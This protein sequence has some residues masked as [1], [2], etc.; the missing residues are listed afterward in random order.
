MKE[1]SFSKY[2][3][4]V[5]KFYDDVVV[6]LKQSFDEK[7]F[8]SLDVVSVLKMKDIVEFDFRKINHQNVFE[9]Y[10]LHGKWDVTALF[11]I[12]MFHKM[13]DKEKGMM[14]KYDYVRGIGYINGCLLEI[15]QRVHDVLS[16]SHIYQ[17]DICYLNF[18]PT[19]QKDSILTNSSDIDEDVLK[20]FIKE[21][22][23]FDEE[24]KYAVELLTEI[25]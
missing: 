21:N 13:T 3:Y 14:K 24:T 19:T 11:G 5:P 1:F 16:A 12:Y 18:L 25:S 8:K 4:L 23:F 15:D 20:L 2:D 6:F 17:Y 10:R 22:I 7:K 9:T